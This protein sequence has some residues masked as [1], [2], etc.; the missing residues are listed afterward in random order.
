MNHGHALIA[1]LLAGCLGTTGASDTCQD[2]GDADSICHVAA[3]PPSSSFEQTSV[4]SPYL[5]TANNADYGTGTVSKIAV[6]P[7][8]SGAKYREIGRYAS[9]TCQSDPLNGSK[10]GAVFSATPPATLCAD[11]TH[12]CCSRAE[13]VAGAN[14]LHQPV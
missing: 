1:L 12:G 3:A 11:G 6:Q 13:N 4:S 14:R 8:A 10:E 5:W 2:S 7:F 9:V